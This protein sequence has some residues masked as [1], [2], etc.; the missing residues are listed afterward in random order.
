MHRHEYLSKYL[1]CTGFRFA[2]SLLGAGRFPFINADYWVK[3]TGI[4]KGAA[5]QGKGHADPL[6]KR[7]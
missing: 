3:G 6:G 7:T 5:L 2:L 1:N 4:A